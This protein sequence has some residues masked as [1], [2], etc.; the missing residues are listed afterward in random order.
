MGRLSVFIQRL[1]NA[2]LVDD[3]EQPLYSTDRKNHRFCSL[4]LHF[5]FSVRFL[6]QWHTY[7]EKSLFF[8][9]DQT[10]ASHLRDLLEKASAA[11]LELVYSEFC[12][13]LFFLGEHEVGSHLLTKFCIT[14][15]LTHIQKLAQ[16]RK[17]TS[18]LIYIAQ[19]P[20]VY[21][22]WDLI[23]PLTL[24]IGHLKREPLIWIISLNIIN[25]SNEPRGI[26]NFETMV[27]FASYDCSDVDVAI[28]SLII[29]QNGA[30][31][32]LVDTL[33]NNITSLS[34]DP[35]GS[36][37]IQKCLQLG[38]KRNVLFIIYELSTTGLF[39]LVHQRFGNYVHIESIFDIIIKIRP[40]YKLHAFIHIIVY[41]ILT[42]C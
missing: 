7:R 40:V 32:F 29:L 4:K 24:K 16:K 35:Y 25:I 11:E 41:S 20:H 28:Q 42:S 19:R 18:L 39:S 6:P 38:T 30:S 26:A 12:E 27:Q 31:D 3:F 17:I 2:L 1:S 14:I 10:E 15:G 22:M 34:L 5:L 23:H 9:V 33:A 37:L 36:F 21:T 8:S 13:H